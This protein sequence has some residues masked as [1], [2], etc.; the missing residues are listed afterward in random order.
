MMMLLL[1]SEHQLLNINL[2]TKPFT[3]EYYAIKKVIVNTYFSD[4]GARDTFDN[5]TNKR[6]PIY[7]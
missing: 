3:V 2:S 4:S 5:N 1:F 6:V 7:S